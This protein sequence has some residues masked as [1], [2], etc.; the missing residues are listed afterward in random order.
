MCG[1][2]KN[3]IVAAFRSGAYQLYHWRCQGRGY[4]ALYNL[5]EDPHERINLVRKRPDIFAKIQQ[6]F[7]KLKG[8]SFN[9]EVGS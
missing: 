2:Y 7:L 6:S 4:Q 3:T 9:Q 8:Q 5:D 1:A